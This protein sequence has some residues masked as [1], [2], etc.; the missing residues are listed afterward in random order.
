MFFRVVFSVKFSHLK[1]SNAFLLYQT[2]VI[3]SF[4][5]QNKFS[6]FNKNRDRVYV[7]LRVFTQRDLR[8]CRL[9]VNR[10]Q[11]PVI[12]LSIIQSEL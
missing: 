11:S 4:C 6:N 1:Y 7:I 9:S 5:F 10:Y 3:K 12:R 8:S 2:K